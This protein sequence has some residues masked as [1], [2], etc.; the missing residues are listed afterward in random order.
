MKLLYGARMARYDIL[1]AIAYLATCVT[2]WT[3]Q[4]D[5]GLHHLMLYVASTT[6]LRMVS[7]CG[8]KLEDL[9]LRMY[10][11]ADFAGC[12]RTQR[13]TSG[14]IIMMCGPSTRFMQS[15]IAKRQSAVSHCTTEAEMI[16]AALGFRAEG[17]PFQIL[18]DVLRRATTPAGEART[19]PE[20]DD[21]VP[22]PIALELE[23]DNQAMIK[24]CNNKNGHKLRHLSRT[25]RVNG[26]F[27]N[28]CVHEPRHCISIKTCKT[29]DMAADFCT[30]RFTDA[31]KWDRLL[32]LNNIVDP[33]LF[34][35]AGS[36][37][38]YLEA[39][40]LPR[41]IRRFLS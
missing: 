30:K 31:R 17:I 19:H 6:H 22:A 35:K 33:A 28:E 32:Y 27:I 12:T 15:G 18:W 13:S 40:T 25:H 39:M 14:I 1:R 29:Y 3:A 26:A 24:I 36:L 37:D 21:P 23:E 11:D 4:C 7:W 8:D 2:K 16:A 10:C 38:E 20:V 41:S 9:M 5:R 34:W